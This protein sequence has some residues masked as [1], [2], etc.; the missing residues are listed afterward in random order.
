MEYSNDPK[1]AFRRQFRVCSA[2]HKSR[3][4]ARVALSCL[5]AA[6]GSLS[7][8]K[9][10]C[11]DDLETIYVTA[12]AGGGGNFNP[13][14]DLGSIP[15]SGFIDQLTVTGTPIVPYAAD[16]SIDPVGA[17]DSPFFAAPASTSS[18][19]DSNSS[20]GG[21]TGVSGQTEAVFE[22]LQL[23]F[24][25]CSA[26]AAAG[27]SSCEHYAN[28]NYRDKYEEC[29]EL[30]RSSLH[31]WSIGLNIGSPIVSGI[32]T[33]EFAD[34]VAQCRDAAEQRLLEELSWC[35]QEYANSLRQCAAT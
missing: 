27:K 31:G 9:P 26:L 20:L 4:G 1:F 5:V 14:Y 32:A 2:V 21:A 6:A 8:A 22:Q 16:N 23:E 34:P 3:A 28:F 10:V 18:P 30:E 7:W 11:N 19:S 12:S 24:E 13:V 25:R 17:F 29:G 35:G 15:E 33:Y